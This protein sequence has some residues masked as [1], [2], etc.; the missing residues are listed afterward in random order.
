MKIL[1]I[2]DIIGR[3]G[4]LAML[5]R[6]LEYIQGHSGVWFATC[7]ELARFWIK[8]ERAAARRASALKKKDA[9]R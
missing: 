1:L 9:K 7:E 2:G 8:K 4:R 3:P 6:I 5:R